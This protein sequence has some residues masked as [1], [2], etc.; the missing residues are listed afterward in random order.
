MRFRVVS[1]IKV[2]VHKQYLQ[3]WCSHMISRTHMV[4]TY[5]RHI[6]YSFH[7]SSSYPLFTCDLDFTYGQHIHYS[8]MTLTCDFVCD[9]F[10]FHMW[11]NYCIFHIWT[12]YMMIIYDF[13]YMISRIWFRVYDDHIWLSHMIYLK[14]IYRHPNHIHT[15][16]MIWHQNHIWFD[17]H[18][19]CEVAYMILRILRIWWSYV[20][21]TYDL[22]R[23]SNRNRIWS[24]RDFHIWSWYTHMM[25]TYD[26]SHIWCS[27]VN[28]FPL[29]CTMKP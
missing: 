10:M 28:I 5:D 25:F 3:I 15:S 9:L 24:Y 12:T 4:L 22:V 2:L 11:H 17:F 29:R 1:L 27:H 8:Y 26:H 13:A 7:I 18:P 20:K 21:F 6:W 16:H 14:I 23:W 19:L